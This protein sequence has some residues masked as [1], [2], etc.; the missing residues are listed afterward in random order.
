MNAMTPGLTRAALGSGR[1]A[2]AG[3][4]SVCLVA[5]YLWGAGWVEPTNF[6]AYL[7]IQS[8]IA[9][10]VVAAIGGVLALRSGPDHPRLDVAR[11]AVLTFVVTAGIVFALIVQQGGVR[12]LRIDVP[13]SDVGLHFV[14]PLFAI[15]DWAV[16]PRRRRVSW[17]VLAGIVGYPVVWG[18][19]TMIRGPIV[20]WYP[21][22]FL[23]PN[24]VGDPLEF[25]ALS[26]AALL[27]F[28]AVGAAL[29]AVAPLPL[30]RATPRTVRASPAALAPA[31]RR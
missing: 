5:R 24:Q 27:V 11:V 29:V 20:D 9:F 25:A 28:L 14:L 3:A 18:V 6:F 16:S 7:T 1:L 21:Y 2:S 22:Y 4:V 12:G 23:D 26:G 19:I 10:A 31:R 30:G 15:L 13:W 17:S 8:N